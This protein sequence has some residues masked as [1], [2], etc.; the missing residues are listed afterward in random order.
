VQKLLGDCQGI[1]REV[2]TRLQVLVLRDCLHMAWLE[3]VHVVTDKI[4]QGALKLGDYQL[5][6]RGARFGASVETKQAEVEQDIKDFL[7]KKGPR[8]SKRKL[9]QGTHA[10]RWGIWLWKTCLENLVKDGQVLEFP[11]KRKDQKEYSLR[12]EE[13]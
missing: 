6:V 13:E 9:Q 11:G 7:K 2:F 3:N 5:S 10:S 1:R 8:I 4:M 12:K